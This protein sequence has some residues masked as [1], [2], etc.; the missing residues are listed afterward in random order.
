M[1]QFKDLLNSKD[2]D[3]KYLAQKIVDMHK[4]LDNVVKSKETYLGNALH[5]ENNKE[6]A[7]LYIIGYLKVTVDDI[8]A[9]YNA[10][11]RFNIKR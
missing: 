1:Y 2:S 4:G 6:D 8:W 11:S 7:L 10:D 5:V 3:V 9:K